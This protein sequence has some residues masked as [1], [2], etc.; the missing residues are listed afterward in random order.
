MVEFWV[1][2]VVFGQRGLIRQQKL[3]SCK[4]V[5]FGKCGLNRAKI[6]VLGQKGLYWGKS[7]CNRAKMAL[8]GQKWL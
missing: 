8:F 1:K 4:F 2:V 3:C 6:V 5:V 7:C